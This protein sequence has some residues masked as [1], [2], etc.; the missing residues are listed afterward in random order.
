M[1]GQV[2][3]EIELR[4]CTEEPLINYLK[5]LGIFRILYKQKDKAVKGYWKNGHFCLKTVLTPEE[6]ETFFLEEYAPSPFFTPWLKDSEC[7]KDT[8]KKN[9]RKLVEE[10][11]HSNNIRFDAIND[12]YN[13]IQFI[14]EES[15]YNKQK[16]GNE[17]EKIKYLTELKSKSNDNLA[18]LIDLIYAITSDTR[19][20]VLSLLGGG[21]NEARGLYSCSYL[22]CVNELFGPNATDSRSKQLLLDSLYIRNNVQLE[23]VTCC[24]F[25]PNSIDSGANLAN[26]WNLVFALEGCRLFRGS[27]TKRYNETTSA[28][29]PFILKASFSDSGH[30]SENCSSEFGSEFW[31]P[32]WHAK[33]QFVEIEYL[34]SES[35]ADFRRNKAKYG[36]DFKL[37]ISSFGVDR[38]IDSFVRYGRLGRNGQ[39]SIAVPLGKYKVKYIPNIELISNFSPWLESLKK[40]ANKDNTPAKYRQHLRRIEDSIF[41][42]TKYGGVANQQSILIELGK[43]EQSFSYSCSDE[44]KPLQG[45]SPEWI[46]ACDDGSLEYRIAC[47]LASIYNNEVGHIREQLEPVKYD[48][49]AYEWDKRKPLEWKGINLSINLVSIL[50]R[51]LIEQSKYNYGNPL[52]SRI[53]VSSSDLIP[54]LEES[55]DDR[56]IA[57][58]F[59][60]LSTIKW[61]DFEWDK[62]SLIHSNRSDENIR[63]YSKY[64]NVYSL[65]KL[66]FPDGP[67]ELDNGKLFVQRNAEKQ[68]NSLFIKTNPEILSLFP[69]QPDKAIEIA[70]RRLRTHGLVPFGTIRNKRTRMDFVFNRNA[71]ERILAALLIPIYDYNSLANAVLRTDLNQT[72]TEAIMDKTEVI[73]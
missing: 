63:N 60:A 18:D 11:I 51:R 35:R 73:T 2:V 32:I 58:L 55:V 68:S 44:L 29:F 62:H 70:S 20:Q 21:G 16:M 50:K 7:W 59:F 4:G 40:I 56:K 54:F 34:F 61:K 19:Y 66:V 23:N 24:L 17:K 26:P 9:S 30:I 53:Q 1:A 31:L 43:A 36:M 10:F 45:L 6:L 25:D 64:F 38:G 57:D 42:F 8:S 69:T 67:Y 33:S 49:G 15:G 27:A 52:R 48:K 71:S 41:R 37:A 5:A 12:S 65:L 39:A 22:T 46:R 3:H 72:T 13:I 14:N 28:S 47:S